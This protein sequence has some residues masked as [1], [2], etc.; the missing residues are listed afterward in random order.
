MPGRK[1]KNKKM[2]LDALARMVKLGFDDTPTKAEFA[3]VSKDVAVLKED[4]A[5]LR[6]DTEAGFTSVAHSL[7]E[8]R[9]ELKD[10]KG[11]DAEI[12]SLR[13]RLVRVERKLGL[14]H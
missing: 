14:S 9:E 10:L 12:T 5:T 8:I 11:M 4:L 3:T 6:R 2:T 7:K 13:E 1:P